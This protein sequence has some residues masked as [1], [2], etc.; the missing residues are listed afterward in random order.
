VI[1]AASVVVVVVVA[2]NIKELQQT[3]IFGTAHI[4]WKVLM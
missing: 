2:V 3:A 4:L 1:A